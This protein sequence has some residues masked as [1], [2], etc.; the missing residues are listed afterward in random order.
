MEICWKIR[1]FSRETK[2]F[3]DRYLYLDTDTLKPVDR[4]RVEHCVDRNSPIDR[5]LL[6]H[7]PLFHSDPPARRSFKPGRVWKC[8]GVD[9]YF[10]DEYGKEISVTE[11]AR[12]QT[13][14]K[15]IV[16]FPPGYRAH[17]IRL[18]LSPNS[19]IPDNP[20]KHI[21]LS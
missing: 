4:H 17:D 21:K 15:N 14:N 10:E 7:R 8:L 12:I 1:G 6:K 9:D 13:G 11:A 18:A 19:P 3:F 20:L 2:D 16:V 5:N